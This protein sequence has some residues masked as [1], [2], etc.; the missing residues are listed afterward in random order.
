MRSKMKTK[1][2]GRR[3]VGVSERRNGGTVNKWRG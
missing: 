1:S 3:V 2:G